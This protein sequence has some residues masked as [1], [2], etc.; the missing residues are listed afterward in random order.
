MYQS[1]PPEP[2]RKPARPAARRCCSVCRHPG[3][4][5]SARRHGTGAG[6]QGSRHRR[7]GPLADRAPAPR[8]QARQQRHRALALPAVADQRSGFR[9]GAGP[10]H[11][12]ALDGGRSYFLAS[13]IAEFEHYQLDDAVVAGQLEPVFAMFNRFQVRNRERVNYAL[14]LLKTEPDFTVDESFEFDRAKAPWAKTSEELNEIWRKR[15][16]NDALSLMLTEK[17]C[18][19]RATSCR[20]ATSACSS[21]PSRSRATTS[22]KCS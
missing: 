13:D 15:V 1:P 4:L 2:A 17:T 3:G 8:Q 20:S 5:R 16:K 18:R 7:A 10:L 12:A 6:R 9:A 14:Q 19:K 21:A 11:R 22:S